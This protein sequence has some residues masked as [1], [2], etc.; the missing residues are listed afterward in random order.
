MSNPN[1]RLPPALGSKKRGRQ[2]EN[3]MMEGE[4]GAMAPPENQF[5]DDFSD[6]EDDGEVVDCQSNDEDENM[7]DEEE[8]EAEIA[9]RL[10]YRP[11]IDEMPE[12]AEMTYDSSAYDMYHKLSVDWP[13]LSFDIVADSMGASRTKYPMSCY[14]A[15]GSQAAGGEDNYIG[16]MKSSQLCKTR[17]DDANESASDASDD[18]DDD[19]LDANP[20]QDPILET[21]LTSDNSA[22]NRIRCMPQRTTIVAGWSESGVV[23]ILD[24]SDQFKQLDNPGEWVRENVAAGGAKAGAPPRLLYTTPTG[25]NGHTSEGYGLAWSLCNSGS[26]ASGDCDGNLR[27]WTLNESGIPIYLSC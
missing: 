19:D 8:D 25:P 27:H 13:C 10:V 20:E 1:K 16:V 6:I 18:E 15:C 17:F 7:N 14:W 11:G 26:L 12:G 23:K 21:K 2:A 9:R 3:D 22:F 4:V 24:F 5:D